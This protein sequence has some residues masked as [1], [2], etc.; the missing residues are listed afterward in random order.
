MCQIV[1]HFYIA[2]ETDSCIDIDNGNENMITLSVDTVY[3]HDDMIYPLTRSDDLLNPERSEDKGFQ[4]LFLEVV[5]KAVGGSYDKAGS[6]EQVIAC[7]P[8][9]GSN[10]LKIP[11]AC[12]ISFSEMPNY[13]P[14]L[15]FS[16]MYFWT[17]IEEVPSEAHVYLH[18][19]D[20]WI[21]HPSALLLQ[22]LMNLKQCKSYCQSSSKQITDSTV[23]L[24]LRPLQ[25]RDY[26]DLRRCAKL[27]TPVQF[28]PEKMKEK[29][30]TDDGVDIRVIDTRGIFS[31]KHLQTLVPKFLKWLKNTNESYTIPDG[32]I[33]SNIGL[34]NNVFSLSQTESEIRVPAHMLFDKEAVYIIVGGLTGVGWWMVKILAKYG[35]GII[36]TFGR[37]S[38]EQRQAEID[39][40]SSLY[41]CHIKHM[42]VDVRNSKSVQD[43]ITEIGSQP[44]Q[45]NI[46]G[47]FHGAGVLDSVLARDLTKD[48]LKGVL[49]PKIMGAVNL[50]R[51]TKGLNLDYFMM[52]SSLASFVGSPGQSNYGA[53]NAFM[54]SL[55]NWR[56]SQGLAAQSVNWGAIGAGMAAE[57]KTAKELEKRGHQLL[58]EEEFESCFIQSLLTNESTVGYAKI[59]HENMK[60]D[61]DN[62]HMKPVAAKM[63]FLWEED[64][65]K[66]GEIGSSSIIGTFDS[67]SLA[68]LEPKERKI[69]MEKILR[70][71]CE[72]IITE[73]AN[74]ISLSESYVSLGS[75][76]M[77]ALNLS[78][79][80]QAA[81]GHNIPSE[82]FLDPT[83]TLQD[84]VDIL[85]AKF[86]STSS[87]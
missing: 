68:F 8:R 82:K 75:D 15:L 25:F 74:E 1:D 7:C 54:D 28:L 61:F 52:T 39:D 45:R 5:G 36:V 6:S 44:Q 56:R 14:G 19:P 21:C 80:L 22:L 48:R 85:C 12:C 64:F 79:V 76:S 34:K 63:E 67:G 65:I 69:G 77:S 16:S 35:A 53:A 70:S 83:F 59:I 23:V 11:K 78:N 86:T 2:A 9:V 57:E 87:D 84:T 37:R 38:C 62:P 33:D 3:V 42:T 40:L 47:I 71:I 73:N 66:E 72:K 26:R 51:L 18:M 4:V 29:L 60:V 55:A 41:K 10:I 81:T 43:A 46:R 27:I 31:V 32:V 50:H 17:L 58:N 24:V 13:R 49:F 20:H 30:I